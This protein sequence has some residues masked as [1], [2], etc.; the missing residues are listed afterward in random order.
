[1]KRL[2]ERA[3]LAALRRMDPEQAHGLALRALHGGLAA[4]PGPVTSERLQTRLAGVTVP[5]PIG[6][7][8]GF[9]KNAE[10]ISPLSRAGFG[11]LEVGA[12]TPLPQPGN[13]KPR[14]FR[15]TEDAAAINRFGF[16]ND[17]MAAIGARL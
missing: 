14:L 3:G 4:T 17:G 5:N 8:A 1:M 2:L 11:F 16:N 15:L 12:A 13:P 9:D 6:L 10:A 7:A